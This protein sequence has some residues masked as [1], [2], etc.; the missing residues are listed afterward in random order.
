MRPPLVALIA[1]LA[2][3]GAAQTFRV[4][5]TVIDSES[6]KPLNRTR[7]VLT[8]GPIAD[9]SLVT[10]PDGR[11]SFDVP[12]G[13]YTLLAAHRDWGDT[14]GQVLPSNDFGAAIVTGPDRDT[15]HLEFRFRAP[16]AIHGKVVDQNGAAIPSATV[17]LFRQTIIDGRKRLSSMGRAESDDFGEYYWSSLYAGTY[18]LAAAGEPWYFSDPSSNLQLTDTGTPPL[19]FGLSYFPGTA[20]ASVAVPLVLRPGAEVQADFILHPTA[21]AILHFACADTNSCGGSVSLYALGPGGAQA[22][23]RTEDVRGNSAI[24]SIRPGRYVVRYT[25]EE[26]GARKI[27]DVP[28][29]EITID[30][31]PKPAPSLSG[32]VIFQNAADRPRHRVYVNLLD[33]DTGKPDTVAL[34]PDGLFSWPKVAASRGRLFL[35]G[36]DGLFIA[37]MSVDGAELKDG[38]IEFPDGAAVQVGLSASDETG[39]LKGFVKKENGEPVPSVLVV[40][41]PSAASTGPRQPLAFQ[42]DSDGS[43]DCRNV[44]ADDYV[45][46]AVENPEF[47]YANPEA[48]RPYLATAKRMRIEPHTTRTED[49]GLS[50]AIPA[51]R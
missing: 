47:E 4:A 15:S 6:G 32:K 8:D 29:G 46:L 51:G 28:S 14:Y 31:V 10:A 11:F 27:V 24:E 43:F 3:T 25:G 40:L 33:E 26:G 44:P 49:I 16:V 36:D 41:L 45:L 20:D 30:L 21:G 37:Q 9:V 38:V 35:S 48:I 1:A 50:A 18:Y 34:G 7:M 12:Q 22:L 13:K 19:P 42:S 2:V 23:V 39:S 5:G 17:E